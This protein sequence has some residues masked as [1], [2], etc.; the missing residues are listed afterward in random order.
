MTVRLKPDP[1]Y[2]FS[3]RLKPDLTYRLSYCFSHS[4]SR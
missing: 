4:L 1:T 3:V 2:C